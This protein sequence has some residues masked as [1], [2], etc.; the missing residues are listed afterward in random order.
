MANRVRII[1]G[2]H[3]GRWINF[4]DIK[5]LRP[6]PDRVR[7]T[8]FNWLGQ[9]TEG[10]TCLDLYT[11]SGALGLEAASRG[12]KNVT[13]IDKNPLVIDACKRN[14]RLL[15]LNGAQFECVKATAFVR[16]NTTKFD[17]VFLDPPFGSDE[18]V[19]V[20]RDLPT[21]LSNGCK[22]YIETGS[23][24]EVYPGFKEIKRSKAG[25]VYFTLWEYFEEN[26]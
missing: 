12:A 5:G 9:S 10:L 22:I 13:F 26:E 3:R 20:L 2:E 16:E 21:H 24:V 23:F 17:I 15:G 8:L 6:T 1:G 25:R 4:P 7:E 11:G 14:C 19:S 18:L